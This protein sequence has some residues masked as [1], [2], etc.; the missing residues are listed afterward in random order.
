MITFSK[1]KLKICHFIFYYI[2]QCFRWKWIQQSK[3]VFVSASRV[4]GCLA[5]HMETKKPHM[6]VI[7]GDAQFR[8]AQ[9][10]ACE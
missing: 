5:I 10:K 4:P 2:K 6:A 8:A 9:N 7:P 3:R 1:G